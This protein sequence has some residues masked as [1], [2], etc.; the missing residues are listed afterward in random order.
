MVEKGHANTN[1]PQNTRVNV[2]M[3]TDLLDKSV[4]SFLASPEVFEK[5]FE[6]QFVRSSSDTPSELRSSNTI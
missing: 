6:D 5:T 3:V 4:R 1:N 2:G